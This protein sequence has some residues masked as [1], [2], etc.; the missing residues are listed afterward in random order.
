MLA[1]F[2]RR[3]G[4]LPRSHA[5]LAAAPILLALAVALGSGLP[6]QAS[7]R[8]LPA[9][10]VARHLVSVASREWRDWGQTE[11]DVS[12]GWSRVLRRG[13]L[14][15]DRGWRPEAATCT[16]ASVRLREAGCHHAA[17]FDARE[18]LARYWREGLGPDSGPAR[19]P[20]LLER[21]VR[22]SAWSAV[23]VSYL[24]RQVG[25]SAE[26]FPFDAAHSNY[27]RGLAERAGDADPAAGRRA[28]FALLLV[29]DTPLAVGDLLCG[30]RNA[31]RDPEIFTL[32]AMRTMP[33][34]DRL[35]E[36]H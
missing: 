3:T 24:M 16:A 36:A 29:R 20:A 4:S 18:R 33:D 1:I 21:R 22:H 12:D 26:A 11:V 32:Q 2:S 8:H 14:E 17:A 15:T 35:R 25:L 10:Q 34:L 23:F 31:S 30:P 7:A 13:A 6:S 5:R 28:Q 19:D 27:L 9:D